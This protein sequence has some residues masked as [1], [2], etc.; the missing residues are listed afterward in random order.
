MCAT[1][2]HVETI[3]A[4]SLQPGDVLLD[5]AKFTIGAI[6]RIGGK[7]KLESY[8][9]ISEPIWVNPLDHVQVVAP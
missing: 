7:L 5:R 8:R 1:R 4:H 3:P 9:N 2:D 6:K